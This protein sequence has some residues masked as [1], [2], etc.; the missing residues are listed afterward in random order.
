MNVL[1]PKIL[2]IDGRR[3]RLNT[4]D[5][6]QDDYTHVAQ[7]NDAE[8]LPSYVELDGEN[9]KVLIITVYLKI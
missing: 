5:C 7:A 6:C 2:V 8:H 4:A 9:M 1:R 3:Y